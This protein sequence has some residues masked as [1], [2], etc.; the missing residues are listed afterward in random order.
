MVQAALVGD[1][2]GPVVVAHG[3]E[4][5]RDD[6]GGHQQLQVPANVFVERF[7]ALLEV[8]VIVQRQ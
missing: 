5:N 4:R 1:R 6:V 3:L 8:L 7:E 2:A